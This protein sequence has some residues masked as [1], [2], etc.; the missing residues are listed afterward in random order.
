MGDSVMKTNVKLGKPVRYKINNTIVN[1][2]YYSDSVC[3]SVVSSVSIPVTNS[4]W[5]SV[6][7]SINISMR[8]RINL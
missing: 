1:S 4:V 2:V 7:D 5:S 6:R 3:Y 8:W